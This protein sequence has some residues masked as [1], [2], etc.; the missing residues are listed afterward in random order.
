VYACA[1]TQ[2]VDVVSYGYHSSRAA[3]A[4][5]CDGIGFMSLFGELTPPPPPVLLTP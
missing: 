4:G 1:Q 5:F 3:P 2:D